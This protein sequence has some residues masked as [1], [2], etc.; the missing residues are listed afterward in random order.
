MDPPWGFKNLGISQVRSQFLSCFQNSRMKT[1]EMLEITSREDKAY[2]W[3]VQQGVV[4]FD[5]T[6]VCTNQGKR[7]D[8]PICGGSLQLR[9]TCTADGQVKLVLRCTKTGC[10]SH[11]SIRQKN[12]FFLGFPEDGAD[13]RLELCQ[14]LEI[15]W[16][17]LLELP[18]DDV[19]ILTRHSYS[20]KTLV[21]WH[22]KCRKVCTAVIRQRGQLTGTEL[23]PIQLDESKFGG[24]RKYNRGRF[25]AKDNEEQEIDP[26][27]EELLNNRNHG[28]VV[29]GPW[30]FGL[31][32]RLDPSDLRLFVVERRDRPTLERIIV[33]HCAKG[34]HIHS[35]EWRAYRHLNRIEYHHKTVCHQENFLDPVT[36]AN[37]QAIE[38]QWLELKEAINHKKRHV[39]LANLQ[40]HLDEY[41]WRRYRKERKTQLFTSFIKDVAALFNS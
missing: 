32:S 2:N 27:V 10:Q 33:E 22:K 12:R 30:V 9:E 7:K 19:L 40:S 31:T 29:S 11:R 41:S 1:H 3:L 24:H 18:L 6:C 25:L 26:L 28:R 13:S 5:D 4:L 20:R 16:Y 39:P 38:R 15:I 21:A 34:S 36:G 8:K 37:T 17:W 14:I 35:D 23:K